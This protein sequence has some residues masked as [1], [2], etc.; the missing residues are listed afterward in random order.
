MNG[1]LLLK[2][3]KFSEKLVLNLLDKTVL[4]GEDFFTT[5][6]IFNMLENYFNRK[7]FSDYYLD[8][9]TILILN[10]NKLSGDE[11]AVFR[12]RPTINFSEELKI[13]KKSV[14][15]QVLHAI[16]EEISDKRKSSIMD[17]IRLN[18]LDY[19]NSITE[20]YRL[21][22]VYDGDDIF[23]LAKILLPVIKEAGGQ[24][25][26][27]QE[28]DQFYYK[29]MLL[30]LV[31]R[32]KISKNKILLVELP[33]YGL[34]EEETEE[35]F[36]L[37]KASPI[38]NI[39]I[40]TRKYKINKVIPNVFNYNVIKNG[41]IYGFNDYDE[42]EKQLQII[43]TPENEIEQKVIE[44]IFQQQNDYFRIDEFSHLVDSF[45]S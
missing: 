9:G 13:S 18:V 17:T 37:L 35:F 28:Q 26:L 10:G 5:Y 33:E 45:L 20:R 43:G 7:T 31:S 19:L 14:L 29:A 27:Q 16:F 38:D 39:I 12:I 8:K 24:D 40:Y 23:T 11:F 36:K 3:Y 1:E 15:G 34:R 25:I 2:G 41:K 4:T 30:D 42:L 6:E 21:S 22:F 32:L 44:Y